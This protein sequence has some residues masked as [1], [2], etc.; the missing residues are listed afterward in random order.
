[1]RA[2]LTAFALLALTACSESP[3]PASD[4]AAENNPQAAIS[5]VD[6][7]T[8]GLG[9]FAHVTVGTA[10]LDAALGLWRDTFGLDVVAERSGADEAL[11]ALW[12]LP[13]DAIARQALL[14]TPGIATGGLH[15]VEFS[16]PGVPV[17]EGAEVFD[18]LP[19][20]LDVYTTDLPARYEELAA[21][22]VSFRAR[23]TEMA[24]PDGS[25]FREVQMPGPDATNIAVLEI[26]G[27]DY[28]YGPAGYAA[29]GP[30][31]IVVDDADI[32]ALFFE[33]ALGL[34]SVTRDLL[35]GPEV[36]KMVGLP[37][38]AGLDFRVLGDAGD[39]MGRIEIVEYQQTEGADR[40]RLATPPNTGTLHVNWQLEDLGPLRANLEKWGVPVTEHGPVDAIFGSGPVISFYSPAGFRI[41]VQQ[42]A[43]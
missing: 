41:E 43:D 9:S 34:E 7:M 35:T 29:I 22:G 11:S 38:G 5:E 4:P 15:F 1:M 26:L 12:G 36:E 37:P 25:M 16:S 3:L 31:V 28:R 39:P 6:T 14:R 42:L 33:K 13:P 24:A 2:T 30:L 20:N 19:K 32:E 40:Y 10:D 18:R 27:N 23:W 8:Q 17:R 21:R